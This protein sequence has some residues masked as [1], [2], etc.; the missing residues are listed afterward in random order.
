MRRIN[1]Y[2][3]CSN[4]DI[5]TI[6]LPKRLLDFKRPKWMRIKKKLSLVKQRVDNTIRAKSQSFGK[7]PLYKFAKNSKS[8]YNLS[9]KGKRI[10]FS[11][12]DFTKKGISTN[13]R[14]MPAVGRFYKTKLQVK[15]YL[16]SLFD[17][18]L[19]FSNKTYSGEKIQY[20]T[21]T[22][23]KPFFRIDILLW[24]LNY[25]STTYQAINQ[26]HNNAVLVNE[27][28]V[29]SNFYVTKG[30]IISFSEKGL[31]KIKD[32]LL[33]NKN[34]YQINPLYFTFLEI[35]YYSNTIVI[36]KD[37]RELSAEDL[38]LLNEKSISYQ[39]LVRK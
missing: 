32:S 9:K 23:A 18:S 29:G 27:K 34:K 38:T 2:K 35:D 21:K 8:N 16:Q 26:I 12:L 28:S 6:R 39:N 7:K 4:V 10:S 11:Y 22:F 25:F 5:S 30:D 33:K 3:L 15:R 37:F 1:K 24:Y 36:T 14:G 13:Y 17:N 31:L 20:M 19:E